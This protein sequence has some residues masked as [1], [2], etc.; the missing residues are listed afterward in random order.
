VLLTN[1]VSRRYARS[2]ASSDPER[3]P[4]RDRSESPQ[5]EMLWRAGSARRHIGCALR[6]GCCA[7]ISE[8]V[9]SAAFRRPF[10]GQGWPPPS[11]TD[12][13]PA[14]LRKAALRTRSPRRT[15]F[16]RARRA[17]FHGT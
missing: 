11:G 2:A 13:L 7:G 4:R 8:R 15:K 1:A 14:C 17:E 12:A 6:V 9:L 16:T 5:V 10:G 3:K